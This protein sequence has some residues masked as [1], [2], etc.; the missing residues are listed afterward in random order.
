[1]WPAVAKKRVMNE[2]G[3]CENFWGTIK[4]DI[5]W[6]IEK[7]FWGTVEKHFW[8]TVEEHFSGTAEKGFRRTVEKH[9]ELFQP[10]PLSIKYFLQIIN[11]SANNSSRFLLKQRKDMYTF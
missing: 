5:W 8:G 9:F 7:N 10:N 11:F 6:T 1:M 3:F 2:W 4:K